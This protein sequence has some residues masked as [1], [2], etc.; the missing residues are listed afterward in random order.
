MY[1]TILFKHLFSEIAWPIKAKFY[2]KPRWKE[3]TSIYK[4]GLG[5]MTKMAAMYIYDK[6]I[7]ILLQNKKSDQL[8]NLEWSIRDS[9]STHFM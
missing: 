8:L 6:N 5:H 1:M 9:M 3:E 7:K 4:N 2:V